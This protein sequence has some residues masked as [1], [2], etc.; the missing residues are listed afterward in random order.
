MIAVRSAQE[1]MLDAYLV[2]RRPSARR[3]CR[4]SGTGW[5]PTALLLKRAIPLIPGCRRH[6]SFGDFS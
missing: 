1:A 3:S 5:W 4:S 6:G 2:L